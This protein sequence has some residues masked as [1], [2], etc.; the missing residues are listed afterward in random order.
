MLRKPIVP[1]FGSA[2]RYTDTCV[3]QF[4]A[5]RA[6]FGQS[7][8]GFGQKR[9]GLMKSNLKKPNYFLKCHDSKDGYNLGG[10]GKHDS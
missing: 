2:G 10:G 9:K 6:S 8:E 7:P 4:V 1:D 3:Q 5:V